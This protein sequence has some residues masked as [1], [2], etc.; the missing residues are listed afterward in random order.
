M[1]RS[2]SRPPGRWGQRCERS[3]HRA[4]PSSRPST[5]RRW[6]A[7]W[8]SAWPA[9]GA[10]SPTIP[11]SSSAC[12]KSRWACCRPPAAALAAGIVDEVVPAGQVLERARDWLLA[13]G[14][15]AAVKPWDAKGFKFPGG[16][17]QTPGPT[18]LFFGVGGGL[19]AKTQGLYPAPEAIL[20]CV[21]DG[22]Q[23]DIDTGLKIEQR[24][25]ARLATS[26]ATKNMIR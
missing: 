2:R 24:Q 5:A 6:A 16:A 1:P 15:Q 14:A 4:S 18:Q 19:L 20:A 13:E 8:R 11:K 21:Y 12:L 17:P 22:C 7:A 26:A 10:S 23:A 9:T 3:K 25:F